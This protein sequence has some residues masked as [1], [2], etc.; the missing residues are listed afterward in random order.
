[1]LQQIV[2]SHPDNIFGPKTLKAAQ[3]YIAKHGEQQLASTILDAREKHL[4]SIAIGENAKFE[5][6]WVNRIEQLREILGEAPKEM[7]ILPSTQK[8]RAKNPPKK[9]T[10]DFFSPQADFL[11]TLT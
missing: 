1:M 5:K 4:M 10:Q 7:A 8:Y 9:Q 3:Q 11:G 6:G 2:G